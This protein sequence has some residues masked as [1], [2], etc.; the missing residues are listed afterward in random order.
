MKHRI[1][2]KVDCV[3]KALLGAVETR[4]LLVHFLNALLGDDLPAPIRA[5][6]LLNP[7]NGKETLDDKVNIVD[8]KAEDSEGNLYQIEIQLLNHRHLPARMLYTWADLYS[9]QLKEGQRYGL[10]QPT[11]SVWLLD[12][13]M[14]PDDGCY[15][16][17][18]Q[19]RDR[20]GRRLLEHGGIWLVEL[21]KF[22][23]PSVTNE[24][25]RWLRFFKHGGQLDDVQ[26]PDWMS[27]PEM[28]QAMSVLRQFSEKERD[29]HAYQS[30]QNALRVQ[31]DIDYELEELRQTKEE[32]LQIKQAKIDAEREKLAAEQEREVAEQERQAAEREREIAEQEK[33]AAEQERQ[34]A[35]QE[36]VVAQ[37][38]AAV[39]EREK[40]AAQAEL[41]HLKALL[42]QR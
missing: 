13:A 20:E 33:L 23:V 14:L 35:E 30:R 8:V 39:A 19:W 37:Q 4:N 6:E 31:A 1:D 7:Y 18:Y 29:Y 41:A 11:Y 25:Q 12:K 5:V 17:D 36:K 22:D 42:G 27:T 34:L 2:P 16:R 3:F 40:L 32:L 26:L 28:E 10:L 21:G 38:K 9:Q 15:L 24:Q